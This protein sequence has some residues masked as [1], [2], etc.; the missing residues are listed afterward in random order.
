MLERTDNFVTRMALQLKG[1]PFKTVWLE[2]P[3]IGPT[4]KKIGAEATSKWEDGSPWYTLPVIHDS[5]T[6]KVVAD[7]WKIA[8]YLEDTYADKPTLFPFG[9][10][11]PVEFFEAYFTE[12]TIKPGM[13]IFMSETCY[14]LNPPSEAFFR[15]TREVIYKLKIEEFAPPGPERNAI[16]AAVKGGFDN[17]AP[18]Y[19]SNGDGTLPFFYGETISYADIVVASYLLWI[20]IVLGPENPEWKEMELW[21]AGRWVKLIELMKKYE[22]VD[23]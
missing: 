7:S 4:M 22:I 11:A 16:W 6:N 14:K 13:R 19:T 5:T 21:N 18:K 8:L 1:L 12:T 2:Y 20:K 17:F 15:R 23:A 3:D 9:V 10:R